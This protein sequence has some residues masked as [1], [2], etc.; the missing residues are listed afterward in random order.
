MPLPK[1]F[2][3]NRTG[4][5]LPVLGLGTWKSKPKEVAGAVSSALATG[6]RHIDGAWIYMNE[7]EIQPVLKDYLAKNPRESLFYATKLW[8]TFYR[9]DLVEGAFNESMEH[10]GLQDSYLDL[11][12]LHWPFAYQ[13]VS[14]E[15]TMPS[16]NRQ[17]LFDEKWNV[18]D[19]WPVLEELVAKGKIRNLGVCNFGIKKL[20]E[21][22]KVA[23]IKPSVL[24]VE[25]HPY[26]PQPELVKFAK[27]NDIALVAYSPL[28]SGG[29][30]SLLEDPVVSFL[31]RSVFL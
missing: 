17:P 16:A 30:P 31:R 12:Y 14:K 28:G 27:E 13:F 11:Y 18:K 23:N 26:N 9:P 8:P 21:L 29:K 24:Q 6:Y 10:L 15:N 20:E 1:G 4:D 25:L 7:K 5:L 3:L 2:K 19:T 22:L